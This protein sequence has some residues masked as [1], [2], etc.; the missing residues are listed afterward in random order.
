MNHFDYIDDV[1]HGESVSLERLAEEVGTP[2]YVYSRATLARHYLV[3][4]EALAALDHLICYSVKANSN[5]AV[6]QLLASLGSGF[7]IVSIGELRRVLLAGGDPAKVVFSGIGKRDDEIEAAL[8]A[9]VC[10]INVE[11]SGEL[12]RVESVAAARSLVA[13][14]SIRVNPDID[15]KTH[16]Y[17]AT[18]LRSS[19]FGV[20]YGEAYELYLQADRSTHLEIVGIDCHIGSQIVEVK[21]LVEA[22]DRMLALID[23]LQEVGI[24]VQHVDMGGG[25]GI[26]YNDEKPALPRELGEAYATRLGERG[27]KLVVEPGRV[28]AGNAGV[29]L[30]RVLGVKSNGLRTFVIVDA[31]MNDNLRPALYDAWQGMAPVKRQDRER[32]VVDVVGPICETGDFLARDRPLEALE[33]GELLAMQS[34]GAYGFSM[35]SNY[36]SRRRAAEVMVHG[37]TYTVIRQREAIEQLWADERLLDEGETRG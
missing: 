5:I 24:E 15:P 3:M 28:I 17:I 1:M 22:L 7:D 18:G 23:R 26:T 8:T 14:I 37:E 34:A 16:P 4:T 11:S 29:L 19:K 33:P 32:Q 9:G 25:L 36:N 35:A 6:L 2:T 21:P 27:L 20:P 30:M 12:E 31:A 13:P 10:C